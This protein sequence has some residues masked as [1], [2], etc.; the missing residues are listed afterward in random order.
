MDGNTGAALDQINL[1]EIQLSLLNMG[2]QETS[3]NQTQALRVHRLTLYLF[4]TVAGK[5]SHQLNKEKG[6]LFDHGY[7]T[8]NF[9]RTCL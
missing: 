6:V 9:V 3:T 1:A 7:E 4:F 5:Q 2:T 8:R